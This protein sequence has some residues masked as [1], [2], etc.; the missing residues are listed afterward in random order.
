MTT[1]KQRQK[2]I[3]PLRCGM[4]N[5]RTSNDKGNGNPPFA[6]KL[7]RVGTRLSG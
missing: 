7:Q 4:T 6:V 5:K 1:K 3:P 2:Q